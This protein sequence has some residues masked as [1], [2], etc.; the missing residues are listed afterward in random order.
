MRRTT[1]P[2]AA[3]APRQQPATTKTPAREKRTDGP[4]RAQTLRSAAAFAA[5]AKMEARGGVGERAF[6]ELQRIRPGIE[7]LV[8]KD[9]TVN[10]IHRWVCQEV[11]PGVISLTP[12]QRY[13]KA[14][15]NYP[16]QGSAE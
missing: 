13:L 14:H 15:L 8:K 4:T 7:L 6:N 11:G 3:D 10:Q 9:L 12:L 5:Q 2:A 1:K 16:P